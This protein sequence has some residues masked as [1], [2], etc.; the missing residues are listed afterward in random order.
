M[1][2]RMKRSRRRACNVHALLEVCLSR[3]PL[4][5]NDRDRLKV[6][7]VHEVVSGSSTGRHVPRSRLTPSPSPSS[8]ARFL[9]SSS[10]QSTSL[11]V[12]G[13][14]ASH[15]SDLRSFLKTC[16][17]TAGPRGVVPAWRAEEGQSAG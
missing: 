11:T 5:R 6:N 17:R 12:F 9:R 1:T 16:A 4:E 10:L 7:D 13:S 14:I 2:A 8:Q 3:V 15:L